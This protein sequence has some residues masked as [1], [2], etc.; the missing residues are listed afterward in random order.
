MAGGQGLQVYY[1]SVLLSVAS[2]HV[3]TQ[4]DVSLTHNFMYFIKRVMQDSVT[5]R[6]I[7][8]TN[9]ATDQ[10]RV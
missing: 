3:H 8:D 7:K 9:V 4:K 5:F 6:Q 1:D 2:W 10:A